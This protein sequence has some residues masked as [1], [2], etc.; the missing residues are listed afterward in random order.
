MKNALVKTSWFSRANLQVCFLIS[1]LG[2]SILLFSAGN[3]SSAFAQGDSWYVGK[4]AKPDTYYTYEVRNLDTNQGRP[5]LMTIYL[6]EFDNANNYWVAPVY[7]VDQG[8][9]YNGTL[10]L[11]DLDM[12][13]LGSSIV[14]AELA[15]YR[16]AYTNSLQ[17]LSSYVPKPGQSLSAPNWGKIAAIGGSPIAPAGSAEVTTPAGTFDTTDISWRYGATNHIWVNPN[18]PYPVKAE[19]FAGVTTGNAPVQYAFELQTTG[20]GEPPIP[21]SEMVTP[22][23]PLTI[24]TQRGTNYIQLI[25]NPPIEASVPEEFGLVFMNDRQEI[26]SGVTYGLTVTSA[27]GTIITELENQKA[28][29][30]TSSPPQIIEFP[31]QGRNT[32]D[33][34]VESVAGQPLGMFVESANFGIVVE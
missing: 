12:S 2:S 29:D 17:W 10:H 33:V 31:E 26:I 21:E 22:E 14:P 13:A 3:S 24:R 1:V 30:G 9:V 34:N 32:L 5:F 28:M 7:V 18:L 11:S 15:P 16:S 23:P 8:N 25:W 27:N 19:T 20:T 4:G 6:K